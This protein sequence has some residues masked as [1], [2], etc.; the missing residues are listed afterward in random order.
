MLA[1]GVAMLVATPSGGVAADRFPKR[2][3]LLV[4]VS[5]LVVS[6]ALTGA[7]RRHRRHPVLDAARRQRRPGG[8]VRAVPAG[9][10]R[11]HRRGRRAG[12]RSARRSCSARPPRR[13]CA[14]SRRRWPVCSIGVVVVRRR[15]R[16]PA[17]RRARA[18]SPRV[19]LLGLPPGDPRVAPT[20]SPARRDGRRRTAT[21]GRAHGARPGRA[22]DD[23]R[24]RHRLPVPDVPAHAGRRAL[25]RRRRR[26]RR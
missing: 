10:D 26:V 8:R 16:V 13:R 9:A 4:A 22:D 7:R 3:V 1:F 15:R 2:T 6:S 5:M 17:G 24:R 12:A 19:V 14:S 18:S 25:R 11:V 21:S 23:R 20:R